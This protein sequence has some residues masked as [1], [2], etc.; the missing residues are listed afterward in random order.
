MRFIYSILFVLSTV[1]AK[2][3][4]TVYWLTVLA[5]ATISIAVLVAAYTV[6]MGVHDTL[7]PQIGPF[8]SIAAFGAGI[9]ISLVTTLLLTLAVSITKFLAK[10]LADMASMYETQVTQAFAPAKVEAKPEPQLEL[11]L[12]TVEREPNRRVPRRDVEPFPRAA[13]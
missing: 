11:P 5:A 10:S 6:G 7:A 8:A 1:A 13:H 12:P 4:R 2:V 9:G 3:M